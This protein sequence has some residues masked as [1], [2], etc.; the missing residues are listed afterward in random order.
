MKRA[1]TSSAILGSAQSKA[2]AAIIVAVIAAGCGGSD[3]P[4]PAPAPMAGDV[5]SAVDTTVTGATFAAKSQ[6]I[7]YQMPGVS[8]ELV[9]ATAIV[10]IPTGATP[11]GGWDVLGWGHGTVG[12]ADKCAPS[13][14]PALF[15]QAD[16]LNSF[17]EA[18]FAIVAPDYEGLGTAGVHPYLNLDSEGR[19]MLYAIDA[20]VRQFPE[21]GN[22]YG[23]FGHSQGGHAALGAA[24]LANLNETPDIALVG[25]VA[26]APASQ[27][28]AQGQQ[29][30]GIIENPVAPLSDRVTTGIGYLSFSA[31]ILAGVEATTPAFDFASALTVDGAFIEP[32]TEQECLTQIR[33]DIA[34]PVGNAI[35][36]NGVLDSLISPTATQIPEVAQYLSGFEP[37]QRALTQ[38]VQLIQG[39]ADTTV[40]LAS[41]QALQTVMNNAGT[42]QALLTT[43]PGADHSSIVPD[44]K[45]QVIQLFDDYFTAP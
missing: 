3:S 10:M 12:V 16:Y 17:L 32:L 18:N 19:S 6:L 2:A 38:P 29:L 13:G 25:T 1:S 45:N 21:L 43:Y 35:G 36:A 40:F 41:T 26:I 4:A 27:I 33:T 14:D 34:V 44:S 7:T 39:D 22:R 11:Q 23:L 31:L 37:G 15:G 24:E 5:V 8:G 20:A 42:T 30:V 9:E 28:D